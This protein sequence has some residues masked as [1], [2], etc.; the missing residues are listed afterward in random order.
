MNR[1]TIPSILLLI[2][3]VWTWAEEPSGEV[4]ESTAGASL[5]LQALERGER[6]PTVR[7]RKPPA[8]DAAA[9]D[10]P[11]EGGPTKAVRDGEKEN[12]RVKRV[13][14][15]ATLDLADGRRIHL[16]GLDVPRADGDPAAGFSA[17]AARVFT[18]SMVEGS[19]IGL[20]FERDRFDRYGRVMAYA[21]LPGD[22]SLNALIIRE[23]HARADTASE[24]RRDYK[25]VFRNAEREAKANNRGLWGR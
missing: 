25:L 24:Y 13:V 21:W 10:L 20:T 11:A 18:K 17:E 16:I 4:R 3:P 9:E 1:W 19:H 15:G 14:D 5:L 8:D 2:L 12:V 6:D 7:V 23:G 22:V